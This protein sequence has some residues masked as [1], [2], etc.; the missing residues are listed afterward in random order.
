MRQTRLSAN[1]AVN[2]LVAIRATQ[3][4]YMDRIQYTERHSPQHKQ[5]GAQSILLDCIVLRFDTTYTNNIN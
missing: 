4:N 2:S 1:S 3:N 5:A